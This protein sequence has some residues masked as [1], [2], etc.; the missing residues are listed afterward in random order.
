M[1]VRRAIAGVASAAL[2]VLIWPGAAWAEP[3]GTIEQ[4]DVQ[5][6]QLSVVVALNDVPAGA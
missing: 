5:D 2:L 6:G 3:T 4:V 1:S